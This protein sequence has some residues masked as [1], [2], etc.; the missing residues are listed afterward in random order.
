MK[1]LDRAVMMTRIYL[2]LVF[3]I[4]VMCAILLFWEVAG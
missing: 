4:A 1:D 3:V 2:G